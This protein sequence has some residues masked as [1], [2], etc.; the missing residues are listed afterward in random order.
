LAIKI[1]RKTPIK[2]LGYFFHTLW[3]FT[4]SDHKTFVVPEALFGILGALSG[5]LLTNN[6]HPNI[7]QIIFRAPEVFL[8]TW[9][10]TL[11]FDLANQRHSESVEEDRL[12]KPFRP[13]AAGRI[14]PTQTK[15]LLLISVPVV[16]AVTY[17][18]LGSY[19]ETV[20]LFSLTWMYND[21]GGSDGHFVIRNLIIGVAYIIYGSGALRVALH[22]NLESYALSTTGYA[23]SCI[24]GAVI[25]TTIQVQ[26]LKDQE[27]DRTRNRHTAPLALGHECAR[28]T[29][30]IPVVLWSIFC[31]L[32][33]KFEVCV[34]AF[35]LTFGMVIAVRVVCLR[36]VS[37]DEKTW[38]MWSYWLAVLYIL[39]VLKRC[40]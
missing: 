30:A 24:I 14:T 36:Y 22:S 6:P 35:L 2:S 40:M 5:P 31:S 16:L 37:A 8:W 29:I 11:V 21:L 10:N 25:F 23:W 27:G 28:W 33:W 7:W 17:F 13:L 12:N 20:L 4:V 3:L 18:Y 15:H 32:F 26:D 9:L 1:I 38:K 34:C 39:P 19:E